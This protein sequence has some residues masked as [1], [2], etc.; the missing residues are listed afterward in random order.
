MPRD[1]RTTV[2]SERHAEL[3]RRSIEGRQRDD[4][5]RLLARTPV[6]GAPP[7][8]PPPTPEVPPVPSSARPRRNPAT[9][10]ARA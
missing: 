10:R 9:F 2:K 6:T 4:K 1:K 8:T 7:P 5:G 3:A